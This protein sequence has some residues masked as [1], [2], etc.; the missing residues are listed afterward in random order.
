MLIVLIIVC[1]VVFTQTCKRTQHA[2]PTRDHFMPHPGDNVSG[3]N[4]GIGMY[5]PRLAIYQNL[6]DCIWHGEYTR[7]NLLD[8]INLF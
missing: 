8:K 7:L 2:N 6:V 4:D 3:P 1:G 5:L